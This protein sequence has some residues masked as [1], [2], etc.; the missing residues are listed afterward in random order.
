[1]KNRKQISIDQLNSKALTANQLHQVQGGHDGTGATDSNN[2][3]GS[4]DLL[5]I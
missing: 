5:D 4:Q 3:I 1:M 2:Y